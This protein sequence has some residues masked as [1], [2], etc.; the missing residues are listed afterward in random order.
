[1]ATSKKDAAAAEPSVGVSKRIVTIKPPHYEFA[2]FHIEGQPDVPLVIHRFSAKLK[3]Q[4]KSKMETG[5]AAG[6]RRVREPKS[7]DA[8]F[9]EARYQSHE[10]WDGF[11]AA[12]IRNAMVSV[13]PLVG[14]KLNIVKM[15]V[16]VLQDGMDKFE[17]QI[18]LVRIYDAEAIKQEDMARVATGE[19]YVSV[20][21]AYLNWKA[22][23]RIRWDA[24]QFTLSDVTNLIARVG[25]QAGIGEGRPNSKKSCGMGWGLFNISSEEGERAA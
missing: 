25:G 11:H 22:Q 18:P 7:T 2:T 6:N 12:S 20:R 3:A 13:A 10:G 19:P 21:A 16:F 24:D 15:S 5:S 8:T 4:M 14:L 1:M 17:P 23:V 9:N